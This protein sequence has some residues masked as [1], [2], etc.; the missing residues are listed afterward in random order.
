MAG[1]RNSHWSKCCQLAQRISQNSNRW[2][3]DGQVGKINQEDAKGQDRGKIKC[4]EIIDKAQKTPQITNRSQIGQYLIASLH[5]SQ[6]H[7]AVPGIFPV[8]KILHRAEIRQGKGQ[9]GDEGS[10]SKGAAVERN[11]RE[12]HY[13]RGGEGKEEDDPRL[14]PGGNRQD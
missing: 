7:W 5:F 1:Q 3:S 12:Q 2:G 9:F 10:H 13:L 8:D 11:S 6:R 4:I 14:Y